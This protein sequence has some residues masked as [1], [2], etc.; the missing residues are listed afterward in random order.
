MVVRAR[1]FHVFGPER[2]ASGY[3]GRP[4][5]REG[6]AVG[7]A[8]SRGGIR[9]FPALGWARGVIFHVEVARRFAFRDL[10]LI[11]EIGADPRVEAVGRFHIPIR[12]GARSGPAAEFVALLHVV[13]RE[14][15]GGD[16]LYRR[17]FDGFRFRR[18]YRCASRGGLARKALRRG[19]LRRLLGFGGSTGNE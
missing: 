17:L 16:F 14:G 10:F 2:F 6:R 13:V 11:D 18:G 12:L 8:D 9:N 19:V 7:A 15:V 4:G 1:A 5:K 3:V